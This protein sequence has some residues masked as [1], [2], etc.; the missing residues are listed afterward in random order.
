MSRYRINKPTF[1]IHLIL[2]D[3]KD[4]FTPIA[5]NKHLDDIINMNPDAT[6]VKESAVFAY[7]D[8]GLK[9]RIEMESTIISPETQMHYINYAKKRQ[10][11]WKY[12]LR[13]WT[14]TEEDGNKILVAYDPVNK[15]ITDEFY[16]TIITGPRAINPLILDAFMNKADQVLEFGYSEEEANDTNPKVKTKTLRKKR[17]LK[18]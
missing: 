18:N 11:K 15:C 14:L 9:S 10:L 17:M 16:N 1:I 5:N 13:D 12:L 8:F 3:H 4:G 6:F 2:Y 7:W